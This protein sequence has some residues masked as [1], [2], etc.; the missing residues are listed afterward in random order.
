LT[1]ITG[2]IVDSIEEE[3]QHL[4]NLARKITKVPEK[5]IIPGEY[6]A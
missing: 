5:I 1:L 2:T 3:R 4:R 6:L